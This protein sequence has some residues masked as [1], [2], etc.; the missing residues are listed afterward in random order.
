MATQAEDL[1]ASGMTEWSDEESRD[2]FIDRMV[3]IREQA[4][5]NAEKLLLEQG[6]A[7]LVDYVMGEVLDVLDCSYGVTDTVTMTDN[8]E[9]PTVF[10]QE[11]P[12]YDL[13]DTY[14]ARV[15]AQPVDLP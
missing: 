14:F 3:G 4:L 8:V 1:L 13:R 15:L 7:A 11:F 9:W 10:D 6:P 5:E 2:L 12:V